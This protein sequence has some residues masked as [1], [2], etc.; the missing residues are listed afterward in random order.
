MPDHVLYVN[1]TFRRSG[2]K[3]DVNYNLAT[4]KFPIAST[5]Q[6]S[7]SQNF[8]R[9]RN[10]KY[11]HQITCNNHFYFIV[12]VWYPLP[13]STQYMFMRPIYYSLYQSRDEWHLTLHFV[14][15]KFV[16]ITVCV[17]SRFVF[18]G[19][20]FLWPFHVFVMVKQENVKNWAS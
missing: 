17:N 2:N 9:K 6:N 1:I 10:V 16:V 8:K 12:V 4:W 20:I 19:S 3:A 18:G 14:D 15:M 5:V 7:W 13:I 11:V